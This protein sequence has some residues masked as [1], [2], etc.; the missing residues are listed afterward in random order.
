MEE[1]IKFYYLT[2]DKTQVN[3]SKQMYIQNKKWVI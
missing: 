1:I 2:L 3:K